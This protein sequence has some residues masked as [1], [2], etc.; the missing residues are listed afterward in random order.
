VKVL[1]EERFFLSLLILEYFFE[2]DDTFL[3]F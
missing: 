3:C 1:F 2:E